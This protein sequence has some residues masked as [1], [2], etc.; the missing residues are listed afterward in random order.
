M[1]CGVLQGEQCRA[2]RGDEIPVGLDFNTVAQ[3]F[4]A[5]WPHPPLVS[6]ESRPIPNQHFQCLSG[7]DS[8][9]TLEGDSE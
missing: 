6:F 2:D 3:F 5:D 8:P 4:A 7:T 1:A 9:M